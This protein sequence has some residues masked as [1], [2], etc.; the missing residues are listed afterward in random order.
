L[1]ASHDLVP[2]SGVIHLQSKIEIGHSAAL[3]SALTCIRAPHVGS[4]S[5]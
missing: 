3:K 4:R 1:Q 2:E 5:H